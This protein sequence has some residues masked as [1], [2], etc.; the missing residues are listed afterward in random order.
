MNQSIDQPI[1]QTSTGRSISQPIDWWNCQPFLIEERITRYNRIENTW[2]T[3]HKSNKTSIRS[4]TLPCTI[5]QI[6]LQVSLWVSNTIDMTTRIQ[7]TASVQIKKNTNG[8][9]TS[10]NEKYIGMKAVA[11]NN[12]PISKRSDRQQL[13]TLK[14]EGQQKTKIETKRSRSNIT[15]QNRWASGQNRKEKWNHRKKHVSE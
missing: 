4:S 8:N 5:Q 1:N 2:Q 3:E 11:D 14:I 9:N 10:A 13:S 7:C 12:Q 15:K 6:S